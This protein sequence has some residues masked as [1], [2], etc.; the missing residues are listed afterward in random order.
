MFL[1]QLTLSVMWRSRNLSSLNGES[2]LILRARSLYDNQNNNDKFIYRALV[3]LKE[4]RK[5]K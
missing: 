4:N 1:A 3:L 5:F 2:T